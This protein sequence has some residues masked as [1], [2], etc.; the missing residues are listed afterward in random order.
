MQKIDISFLKDFIYKERKKLGIYTILFLAFLRIVVYPLNHTYT[1]KKQEL[2]NELQAYQEDL[3]LYQKKLHQKQKPK[4]EYSI[5]REEFY[6]QDIKSSNITL[7][8][9]EIIR[10]FADKNKLNIQ[11]FEIPKPIKG[12]YIE[13]ISLKVRIIN[14]SD[15]IPIFELLDIIKSMPRKTVITHL[16]IS[17][18]SAYFTI[19]A[20]KLVNNL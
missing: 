15:Y 11:S 19:N 17:N 4:V 16:Q 10:Y 8:I 18:N 13:T 7:A 1:V 6:P 14:I 3:K 9:M 5:N 2:Q 20:Y 12:K